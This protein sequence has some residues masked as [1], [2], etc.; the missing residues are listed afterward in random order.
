[1]HYM[2]TGRRH[3][4]PATNPRNQP[5]DAP[6]F[7]A[8]MQYLRR[9]RGGMPAGVSLNAP[10]NQVSANN[11]IFPGFFAGLLGSAHDPVFVAQDPAASDFRPLPAADEGAL[12]RF[13][14]RRGLL[15]EVDARRHDL[16]AATRSF[17]EYYER[18]FRLVAAPA[19]RQAF[20]L[21]R[22]P[23][24]LRDRY[25][26]SAFGQGLLLARR[27]VEA[28]VA[29][30]T[31]NWARD[32][33][34][35]DTHKDNFRDLKDKLLPPFD[36]GFAALLEDLDG[37]GLLG[38]TLVMCLGEFGRTP[39]INPQAG[40]DHW[41][42]CNSVV[43]AGGGVRGGQVR[44]ASDGLAAYPATEVH[45]RLGRPLRLA[46]GAPLYDLFS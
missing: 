31:V 8:V 3:A 38:E 35:W 25:G 41:A 18:A 37:R 32:D 40:R 9:G 24:R 16:E 39:R 21:K 10:A 12:E 14:R 11:H 26:Q 45:D 22:E 44:G 29:L 15:A 23:D 36:R 34:Y 43:L 1:M 2:L 4:Q 30:V 13:R 5:T 27:L 20:D 6:T 17:D 46:D 33:A 42:A 7:G 28:G 19:V